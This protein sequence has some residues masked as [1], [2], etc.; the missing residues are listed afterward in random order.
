MTCETVNSLM[1]RYGQVVEIVR[2]EEVIS[3]R[4]FLQPITNKQKQE[5]QHLPTPLGVRREDRF[6]YLGQ[7]Q[8]EVTAGESQ[9]SWNGQKFD[10][11]SAHPI[12]VGRGL[13]HWWAVLVPADKEDA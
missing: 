1:N 2:A 11:Q 13:S 5:M 4:A 9:V 3:A 8:V 7:P 12:Y 10:V 6:L